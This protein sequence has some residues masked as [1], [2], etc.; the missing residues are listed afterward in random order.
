MSNHIGTKVRYRQVVTRTVNTVIGGLRT[1]AGFS[2]SV[3]VIATIDTSRLSLAS[4]TNMSDSKTFKANAS[5]RANPDID[6]ED[7]EKK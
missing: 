5:V 3:L 1:E 6:E 2:R 7:R 4:F